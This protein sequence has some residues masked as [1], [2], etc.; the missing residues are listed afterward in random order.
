MAGEKGVVRRMATEQF[1]GSG[2]WASPAEK[3]N[4]SALVES[5]GQRKGDGLHFTQWL[6]K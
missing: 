5:S 6:L 4:F 3:R 1:S 2:G